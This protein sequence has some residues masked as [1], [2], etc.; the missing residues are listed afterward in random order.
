M[1]NKDYKKIK[2]CRLCGSTKL[3]TVLILNKSPLCDAYLKNKRKQEFY[4]LKLCL[5]NVCKFV[6]IDTIVDPKIIYPYYL[7]VTNKSLDLI[8]H[9]KNYA[10]D[11]YKVLTR[12]T[13]LTPSIF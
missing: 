8:N 11:I 10:D 12:A 2:A 3:S 1:T 5:C 4:D 6:Q 7:Y 9:F 13:F